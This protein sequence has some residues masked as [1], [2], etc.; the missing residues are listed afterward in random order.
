MSNDI[1]IWQQGSVKGFKLN[2]YNESLFSSILGFYEGEQIEFCI[3]KKKKK[4]SSA[5]HAFYRGILLPLCLS[6]NLFGGWRIDDMHDY[7]ADKFLGDI[8][9]KQ[10]DGRN[11]IIR[12]VQSTADL[13]QEQMNQ[14]INDV[15]QFMEEHE[16][17]TPEPIKP[18]KHA[19]E[20]IRA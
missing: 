8:K 15:R 7:F 14:F 9:T 4:V 12:T 1:V 2:P 17:K 13:S 11:I 16:I 5:T 19:K 20:D 3:R 6:S 10:L 18:I